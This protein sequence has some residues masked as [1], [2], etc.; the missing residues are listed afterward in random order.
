M[1]EQVFSMLVAI[2]AAIPAVEWRPSGETVEDG[3]AYEGEHPEWRFIVVRPSN[4]GCVGAAV[5]I[6]QACIVRLTPSLATQACE[7]AAAATTP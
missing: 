4:G 7:L 5:S 6:Q 1:G 2:K 3:V